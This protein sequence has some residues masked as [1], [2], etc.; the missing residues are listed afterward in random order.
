MTG[1]NISASPR[2]PNWSSSPLTY[3]GMIEA[4]LSIEISVSLLFVGA[5]PHS[6]AAYPPLHK[7]VQFVILF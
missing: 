3:R 2:T 5:G 4:I 6:I 7:R 1:A